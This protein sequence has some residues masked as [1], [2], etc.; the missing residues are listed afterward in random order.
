MTSSIKCIVKGCTN[1]MHQGKFVGYLCK[2]CYMY[3][4]TGN[5]GPTDSYLNILT[6]TLQKL[7]VHDTKEHTIESIPERVEYYVSVCEKLKKYVNEIM[8]EENLNL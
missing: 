7:P 8:K 3:L 4:S 5:I 1:H 6:R 2:P